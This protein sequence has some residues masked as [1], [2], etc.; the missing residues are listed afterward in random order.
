MHQHTE[1][2]IS[3]N[4]T[5]QLLI[6]RHKIKCGIRKHSRNILCSMLS[7]YEMRL[8]YYT[9]GLSKKE[10]VSVCL[11]AMCSSIFFGPVSKVK[12]FPLHN[13]NRVLFTRLCVCLRVRTI[14]PGSLGRISVIKGQSLC[15]L[16]KKNASL[17][18]HTASLIFTRMHGGFVFLS[19]IKSVRSPLSFPLHARTQFIPEQSTAGLKARL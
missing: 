13:T 11:S 8:N 3:A 5:S 10:H 9:L 2:L 16:L 17:N 14:I 12:K 6:E 15:L 1:T 19:D 18:F 4:L 7:Y